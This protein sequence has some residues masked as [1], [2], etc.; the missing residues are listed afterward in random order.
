MA[1]PRRWTAY[2]KRSAHWLGSD[3]M[4]TGGFRAR[5]PL[6]VLSVILH[7]GVAHAYVREVTSQGV[8][9]AWHQ[10]CVTMHVY[11]GSPPPVLAATDYFAASTQAAAAW[12]YPSLACTDL[13]LAVVAESQTAADVGYDHKNVIV[14]RQDTWCRHG[15]VAGGTEPDCYPASAL[16]LTSVFKNVQTGEILD[17]DIELNAVNY[18]FGDRVAQPSLA[19]SKTVDFQYVLTHEL[20]HVI[21]L[22][23]SCY[24]GNSDPGRLN[25][26]MGAPELDCYHNSALPDSVLQ[27]I[28]YPSVD[29]TGDKTKQRGLSPD[30]KQGDCDVYPHVHDACPALSSQGGCSVATATHPATG[31]RPTL[32]YGLAL[33]FLASGFAAWRTRRR[34]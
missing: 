28:M 12:S 20:G 21:G 26:N 17:A 29:L 15:S 30:D 25:D 8:P 9:V 27:T 22:D 11:L 13:R 4:T 23:H 34:F 5:F 32:E 10:P 16:A 1:N 18:T 24:D 31:R 19:T 3:A 6:A 7:S 14:F 33:A 2:V